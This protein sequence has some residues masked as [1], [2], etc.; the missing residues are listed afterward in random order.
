MLHL[1][2]ERDIQMQTFMSSGKYSLSYAVLE[3]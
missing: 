3:R 1:V 2:C